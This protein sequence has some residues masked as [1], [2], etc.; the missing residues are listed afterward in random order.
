M[1]ASSLALFAAVGGVAFVLARFT[2]PEAEPAPS[3]TR[4]VREAAPPQ[5]IVY[6]DRTTPAPQAQPV[7]APPP[8]E[9]S[10]AQR[11]AV[12][13]IERAVANALTTRVWR[14]EDRRLIQAQKG[15]VEADELLELMRPLVVAANQ[16]QVDVQLIG[17]LF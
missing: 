10:P 13:N 15:H 9:P 1:R 6:V 3:Q 8:S 12:A 2:A 4:I 7:E 17:S 16:Q 11:T 14:E 5:K